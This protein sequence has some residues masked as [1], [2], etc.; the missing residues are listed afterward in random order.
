MK[1]GSVTR[2]SIRRPAASAN[3]LSQSTNSKAT[4]AEVPLKTTLSQSQY[5]LTDTTWT[6]SVPAVPLK[7]VVTN[8]TTKMTPLSSQVSCGTLSSTV[9]SWVALAHEKRKRIEMLTESSAAY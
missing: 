6:A 3:E 4:E 1:S 2:G 9:P 7:P 5:P 8:K